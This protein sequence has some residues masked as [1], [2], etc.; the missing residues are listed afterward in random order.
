MPNAWNAGSARLLAAEGFKAIGTTSAGIA[1]G[2]GI[3]D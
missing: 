1:F 2:L 3:P